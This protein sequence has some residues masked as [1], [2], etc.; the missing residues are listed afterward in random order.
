[1]KKLVFSKTSDVEDVH[2]SMSS[3]GFD[4]NTKYTRNK[5]ALILAVEDNDVVATECLVAAGADIDRGDMKGNTALMLAASHGHI[6]CLEFLLKAGASKSQTNVEG[7]TA[8][9]FAVLG[10]QIAELNGNI[11]K[12]TEILIDAGVDVNVQD[13]EGKT[14]LMLATE[15]SWGRKCIPNLIAAGADPSM[16]DSDGRTA[17]M[18]A[19]AKFVLH[20]PDEIVIRSSMCGIDD[21]IDPDVFLDETVNKDKVIMPLIRASSDLNK[22]DKHGHTALMIACATRH[23]WCV[24]RLVLAGADVNVRDLTGRTPLMHS[25]MAENCYGLEKHEDIRLT[26][27]LIENGAD[28]NAQDK[29]GMTAL[30]FASRNGGY[31]QIIEHLVVSEGDNEPQ[32]RKGRTA[33]VH[34]LQAV[35]LALASPLLEDYFDLYF[36][37]LF[38][39]LSR[40]ACAKLSEKFRPLIEEVFKKLDKNS[41]REYH[42]IRFQVINCVA[43]FRLLFCPFSCNYI[44]SLGRYLIANCCIFEKDLEKMKGIHC[45]AGEHDCCY[46]ESRDHDGD[47]DDSDRRLTHEAVA[48]P[49]PLV[50]LAFIAVSSAI[51]PSFGREQRIRH[52]GLPQPIQECLLFQ[53]PIASLPVHHWKDIPMFFNPVEYEQ[54]P[55]PYPLLYNWPFGHELVTCTCQDC[56]GKGMSFK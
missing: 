38:W 7:K 54:Q 6:E 56:R 41:C 30:M 23:L 19:A 5:T 4:I 21:F 25:V 22:Q 44:S 32:D 1:M 16:I 8:L 11:E 33:V 45:V 36:Y 39:L 12:C 15:N 55:S 48:Y 14:A 27:F 43:Y 3:A 37:S 31:L 18:L 28:V 50:K 35:R 51:G 2:R 17:L 10:R 53:R 47:L 42:L 29:D 34:A 49:W 46:D 40:G 20:D 13:K 26:K 52:T 9:M 24:I